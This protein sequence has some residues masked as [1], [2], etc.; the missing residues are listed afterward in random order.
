[1]RLRRDPSLRRELELLFAVETPRTLGPTSRPTIGLAAHVFDPPSA[2]V[3]PSLQT[4]LSG[5]AADRAL[6]SNR[7]LPRSRRRG[8]TER[9]CPT[10]VRTPHRLAPSGGVLLTTRCSGL[11]AARSVESAGRSSIA[12]AAADRERWALGV[13]RWASQDATS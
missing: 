7:Q 2:M 6:E 1:M 12:V 5:Y 8:E 3:A 11:L 4:Y 13:G 9:R 10:R